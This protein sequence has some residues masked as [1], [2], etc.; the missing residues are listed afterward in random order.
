MFIKFSGE[1]LRVPESVTFWMKFCPSN[2]KLQYLV[3]MSSLEKQEKFN[4]D[5]EPGIESII[6]IESYRTFDEADKRLNRLLNILN[7]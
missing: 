6:R 1:I 2:F 5:G 4:A 7:N 3:I